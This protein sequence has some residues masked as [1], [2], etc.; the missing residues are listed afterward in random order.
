MSSSWAKPCTHH[1]SAVVAAALAIYG[2]ATPP[3]AASTSELRSSERRLRAVIVFAPR[4]GLR[5]RVFREELFDPLERLLCGRLRRHPFFHNI[6]PANSP[7]VLVLD[8]GV[9][10]VK[11]PELRQRRAE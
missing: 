1:T 8:L 7:N 2:R 6:D 9:C 3:A 5:D 10:G 4:L 11:G